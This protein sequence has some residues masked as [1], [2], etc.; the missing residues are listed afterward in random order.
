[1]P[2]SLPRGRPQLVGSYAVLTPKRETSG[3]G[4]EFVSR[5]SVPVPVDDSRARASSSARCPFFA[6]DRPRLGLERRFS[7]HLLGACASP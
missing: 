3:F 7:N 6:P 1:M 5:S 2:R 4:R